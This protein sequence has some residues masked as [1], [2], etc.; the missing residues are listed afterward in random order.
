[1]NLPEGVTETQVLDAIENAVKILAPS[2]AFGIYDVD[3]IKQEARIMGLEAMR[4]YDAARPL[5]NF[6]YSHIK[7]RLI[8]LQ[9]DKL[10]RNDAPCM[11]CHH[12]EGNRSGHPNGEICQKY[13]EWKKRNEAK[14]NL[15]RPLDLDLISDER[16]HNAQNESEVEDDAQTNELLRKI[17]AGLSIDMR[18]T[19]LQMRSGKTVPKNR[20]TLV[21]KEIRKI[22]G[23]DGY[24]E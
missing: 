14:A 15:M 17:D 19:Y 18:A 23:V 22:L 2:F 8:N 21:E 5:E 4:R 24:A 1:M 16:E 10:H 11:L 7:N 3:D 9:R 13:A 12:A 6:L 20:R